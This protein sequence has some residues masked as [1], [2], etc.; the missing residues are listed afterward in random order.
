VRELTGKQRRFLRSLGQKLKPSVTIG[1]EHISD[2]TI[3]NIRGLLETRELVKIRLPASLGK[4]RRDEAFSLARSVGAS[5]A[6]VIGRS[7]LLYRP[8]PQLP[9]EQRIALP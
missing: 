2:A 3:R 4:H 5:C 7:A 1:K 9:S 6:G 8:N